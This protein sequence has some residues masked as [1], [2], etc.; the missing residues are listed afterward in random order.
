MPWYI[1]AAVTPLFYS[2]TNFIEKFLIEKKIKDPLGITALSCLA[3]GIIGIFIALITGFSN[4]GTGQIMILI[5]AGILLT[6]YLIPYY[7]ALKIEDASRIIPLFQFIPVITLILSTIILKETLSGKQ[8]FG[9]LLVVFASFFISAEKVKGGTFRPR[10][11]LYFMFLASFMYGLVGII[12]RFVVREASFWTTLSYEYIGSGV[13]GVLLLL[14]PKVR[15]NLQNQF[16]AVKS[17][18]GIISFNSSIAII[19]QVSESYALSLAAVP[20]VNI[21][22]SIQPA[23]SLV[24]GIILTK[25]FPHLIKEDISKS[26]LTLK[27]ISILII[28]VGMYLVYF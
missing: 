23:I 13:G 17:S 26:T 3:S 7:E 14:I 6:F 4:P 24:E 2:F 12:F 21:I 10:K 18:A 19:A 16:N 15:K 28:F 20:L 1:F 5:F 25:K 8:I 27:L 9:M 22:G 11:S